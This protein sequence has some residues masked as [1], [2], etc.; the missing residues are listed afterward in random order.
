VK[1]RFGGRFS[2][3]FR[4]VRGTFPLHSPF[5]LLVFVFLSFY[6]A[7]QPFLE[8]LVLRIPRISLPGRFRS[9][10]PGEA[11]RALRRGPSFLREHP[12]SW[13]IAEWIFE[14]LRF[15]VKPSTGRGDSRCPGNTVRTRPIWSPKAGS[16]E[17]LLL[18]LIFFPCY[19][20]AF[21]SYQQGR[22]PSPPGR[23]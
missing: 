16:P 1:T 8:G 17:L 13:C 5:P 6:A 20:T 7:F 18:P 2:R 3:R 4:A 23:K 14:R 12:L 21:G 15:R 22:C 10:W 19:S 9:G 11:R